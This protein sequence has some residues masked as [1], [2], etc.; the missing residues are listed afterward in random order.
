MQ[1]RPRGLPISRHPGQLARISLYL[2]Y[3]LHEKLHNHILLLIISTRCAVVDINMDADTKQGQACSYTSWHP[4]D[5]S[6]K[7]TAHFYLP[8]TFIF[9]VLSHFSAF[10]RY[11]YHS[12][13]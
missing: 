10:Y 9:C 2:V 6:T 13:S 3:K 7:S 4:E 8:T 1:M 11:V 12:R 5:M